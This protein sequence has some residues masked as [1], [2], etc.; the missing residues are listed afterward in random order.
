MN[1]RRHEKVFLSSESG[2]ESTAIVV[3]DLGVSMEKRG[4]RGQGWRPYDLRPFESHR[5]R[6]GFNPQILRN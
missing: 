4:A 2:I 3:A 6:G 1:S 5:H